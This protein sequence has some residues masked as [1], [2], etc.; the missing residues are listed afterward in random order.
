MKMGQE[1]IQLAFW[2]E[3]SPEKARSNFDTL[4]S[5][6]RKSMRSAM[7][8]LF[9]QDY[10]VLHQGILCLQNCVLDASIFQQMVQKGFGHVKRNEWWQAANYFHPAMNLWQNAIN[11]EVIEGDQADNFTSS[12]LQMIISEIIT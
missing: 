1:A 3:S 12:E 7:G 2:P 5:R 10:L 9:V 4:L 8:Q 11:A 6:L